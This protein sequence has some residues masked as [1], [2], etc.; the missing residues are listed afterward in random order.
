MATNNSIN[1][2]VADV[3]IFSGVGTTT[4]TIASVALGGST[5]QDIV[6]SLNTLH[7]GSFGLLDTGLNQYIFKIVI[8]VCYKYPEYVKESVL[9]FTYWSAPNVRVFFVKI[10]FFISNDLGVCLMLN[11]LSS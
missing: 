5:K 8:D 10:L 4:W 9:T 7:Y 2:Q 11:F 1:I 6:N 3:Q